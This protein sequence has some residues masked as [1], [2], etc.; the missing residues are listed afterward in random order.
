MFFFKVTGMWIPV[1]AT[2]L[3]AS[4]YSVTERVMGIDCA[5]FV[6]TLGGVAAQACA[7]VDGRLIQV[8]N[9]TSGAGLVSEG[10]DRDVMG[11]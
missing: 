4:F 5:A 7:D 6:C 1:T 10:V 3:W 11:Q 8:T 9:S 2:R